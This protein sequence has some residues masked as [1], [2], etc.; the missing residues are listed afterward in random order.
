MKTSRLLPFTFLVILAIFLSSCSGAAANTSWPGLTVDAKTKVG[1][2]AY[3][4]QVYAI[5]LENGSEVWKFPEKTDSKLTFFAPPVLTPDGQLLV[6]G[7]DNAIHSL[8][9]ANGQENQGNWPFQGANDR[10]VASPLVTGDRV[11]APDAN[12]T[13][14]VLDLTGKLLWT[15]HTDKPLWATPATDGKVIYLASMDRHVY[16]LDAQ[17]GKLIWESEDLGGAVVGTPTIGPDGTLYVGS[18]GRLMA[19][20]NPQNGKIL[21]S[22]PTTGWVWAAPA[23]DQGVLFF[24]DLDGAFYAMNATDGAVSWE[25]PPAESAGNSISDRSVVISDTVYYTAENGSLF[26]ASTTDGN[27][28]AII[29]V[30]GKLYASP[31]VIGDLFLLA[32]VGKGPFL[33]AVDKTGAEKW[34][35]PPATK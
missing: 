24:G 26:A 1:Y 10:Y 13:M 25:T 32:P 5:N 30:D 18:F 29:Q 27:P 22:K 23:L 21:W 9:P 28:K 11:Y 17:S 33:M 20:L 34:V 19:A 15:Y 8:N 3:N 16:A 2:V 14:Y 12:G 31:Q 35:Y 4:Q 6:A 7:Y